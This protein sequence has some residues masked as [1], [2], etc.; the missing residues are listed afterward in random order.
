MGSDGSASVAVN[1]CRVDCSVGGSEASLEDIFI[2]RRDRDEESL[3]NSD[4]H[5]ARI[6]AE[7]H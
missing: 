3:L 7:V 6:T 1:G 4:N 2:V 5:C